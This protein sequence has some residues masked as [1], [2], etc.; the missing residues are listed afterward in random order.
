MKVR[1]SPLLRLTSTLLLAILAAATSLFS[2]LTQAISVR[3]LSVEAFGMMVSSVAVLGLIGVAAGS[4]QVTTVHK[5]LVTEE[6][7]NKQTFLQILVI[8]FAASVIF[9]LTTLLLETPITTG[10]IV[11][12]W[13]PISILFARAIGELQARERHVLIQ[14]VSMGMTG[15]TLLLTFTLSFSEVSVNVLLFVRMFSTLLLTFLTFTYLKLPVRKSLGFFHSRLSISF[16]VVSNTWIISNFD[17]L[18]S[19]MFLTSINSGQ[20]A[21]AALLVNSSLLF[22]GLVAMIVYPKL[23]KAR[24]DRFIFR[25]ATIKAVSASFLAQFIL[26]L[27]FI[28]FGEVMVRRLTGSESFIISA[29]ITQ[30]SFTALPIGMMIILVQILL[31]KGIWNDALIFLGTTGIAI[32][33]IWNQSSDINTFTRALLIAV[34]CQLAVLVVQ[35]EFI[36]RH[37]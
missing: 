37:R 11:C 16:L 17:I 34:T 32:A 10:V 19:R 30:L 27:F 23:L 13:V 18:L 9:V 20:I 24:S 35:S 7:S 4:I 22:P 12:L 8:L 25:K 15:L 36:V 2:F 1:E 6:S 21:M 26:C 33:Y 28:K 31:A 5:V 14:L 29:I 3:V